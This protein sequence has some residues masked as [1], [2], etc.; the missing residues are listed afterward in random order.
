M[1]VGRVHLLLALITALTLTPDQSTSFE[2]CGWAL[3]GF[4]V[5]H[6]G[7]FAI[8]M[9]TTSDGRMRF[10]TDDGDAAQDA[11]S[12]ACL[13]IAHDF[14]SRKFLLVGPFQGWR[15]SAE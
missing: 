9:E 8:H 3:V 13:A 10:H 2:R 7:T 1:S 15:L 14:P 5:G 4:R 12:N 11:R 6:R